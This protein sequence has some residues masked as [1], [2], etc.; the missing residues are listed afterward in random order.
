MKTL[1]CAVLLMAA[2]VSHAETGNLNLTSPNGGEVISRSSNLDIFWS[3]ST[4]GVSEVY[5]DLY[6]ENSKTSILV[7]KFREPDT[8]TS[9]L[10][11][12]ASYHLYKA[13][14]YKVRL[15][16]YASDGSEVSDESDGFFTVTDKDVIDCEPT[17]KFWGKSET[18]TFTVSWIDAIPGHRYAIYLYNV[19]EYIGEGYGFLLA[20]GTVPMVVG[21]YSFNSPFLTTNMSAYPQYQLSIPVSG[22]YRVL[23]IDLETYGRTWSANTVFVFADDVVV[24]AT[25]RE[26][27]SVRRGESEWY[28]KLNVTAAYSS[29][30]VSRLNIPFVAWV[31]DTNTIL[32]ISLVDDDIGHKVSPSRMIRRGDKLTGFEL[33]YE[34]NIERGRSTTLFLVVK[35]MRGQGRFDIALSNYG[36]GS[37]EARRHVPLSAHFIWQWGNGAT[38]VP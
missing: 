20:T 9:G 27:I 11:C 34:R 36:G 23:V 26:S 21:S 29:A 18:Q 7:Q 19:S 31:E 30:T 6:E 16:G 3:S 17:D 35:V 32:S 13:G 10:S 5:L 33:P 24:H 37:A 8:T 12:P 1:L 4:V 14:S 22:T 15:V 25:P 2:C 28:L 38:I